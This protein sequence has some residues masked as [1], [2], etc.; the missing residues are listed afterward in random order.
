M[1]AGVA[2]LG[3]HHGTNNGVHGYEISQQNVA[4][5]GYYWI[6]SLKSVYSM[7]QCV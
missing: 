5:P 4:I 1:G 7:S 2:V 6:V 3:L